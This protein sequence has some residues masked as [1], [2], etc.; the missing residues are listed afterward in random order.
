[1]RN[2]AESRAL[3]LSGAICELVRKGLRPPMRTRMVNGIHA[4]LNWGKNS[5]ARQE[6]VAAVAFT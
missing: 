1:V 5:F 6:R 2:Y 3:S 4:N